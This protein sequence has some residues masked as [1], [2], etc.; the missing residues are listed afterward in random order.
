MPTDILLIGPAR[1]V[2]LSLNKNFGELKLLE[3]VFMTILKNEFGANSWSDFDKIMTDS[4]VTESGNPIDSEKV[5]KY[6]LNCEYR[7]RIPE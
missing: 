4:I 7:I 5:F 2:P 6:A 1:F 3:N